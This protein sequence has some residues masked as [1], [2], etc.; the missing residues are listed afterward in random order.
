MPLHIEDIQTERL[1]LTALSFEHSEAMYQLWSNPDVCRYSGLVTDYDRREIPMPAA[2]AAESDK[3]ID[4][5]LRASADEWG[6]RWAVIERAS[7]TFLGHIG[8]NSLGPVSE[9]AYHL[10]P[11]HWGKGI[12]SEAATAAVGWALKT[13]PNT[14]LEAFIEPENSG[15]IALIERLGFEPTGVFSEGA[16]CYRLPSIPIPD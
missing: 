5:W 10:S 3:I 11:D 12:M 2:S 4:F 1:L 8:F 7:G 13:T 15:S 14:I 16:Q 6:F 9:I